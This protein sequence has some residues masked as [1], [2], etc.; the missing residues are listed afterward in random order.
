MANTGPLGELAACRRAA[1]LARCRL[2]RGDDL[3]FGDWL[4]FAG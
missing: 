3:F 2:K 1:Q 4:V